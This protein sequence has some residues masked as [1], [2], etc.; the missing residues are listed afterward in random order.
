MSSTVAGVVAVV[1]L[2]RVLDVPAEQPAAAAVGARLGMG[3]DI[4]R[5]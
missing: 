3:E 2:P 5:S 1:S 4:V